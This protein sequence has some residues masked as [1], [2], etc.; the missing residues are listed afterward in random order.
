[1]STLPF[2]EWAK[3]EGITDDVVLERLDRSRRMRPMRE[4]SRRTARR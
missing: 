1:M 2:D 3:E 4:R